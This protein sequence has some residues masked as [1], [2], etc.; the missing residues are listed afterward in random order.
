MRVNLLSSSLH[1]LGTIGHCRN[2]EV[3]LQLVLK[4]QLFQVGGFLENLN[5]ISSLYNNGLWYLMIVFYLL[6][7]KILKN[8]QY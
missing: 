8:I 6:L 7:K 1:L 3:L 2:I 5:I 4:V